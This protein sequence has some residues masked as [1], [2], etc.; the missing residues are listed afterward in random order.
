MSTKVNTE[1]IKPDLNILDDVKVPDKKILLLTNHDDFIQPYED[2]LTPG[3]KQRPWFTDFF[4]FCLPLSMGNQ[5]GFI[6][7]SRYD[8][9]L[10]WTGG[11]DLNAV[12][13][14][15]DYGENEQTEL[16]LQTFESHFGHGTVTMQMHYTMRT[17]PGVNILLKEPP[18]YPLPT[19][20]SVMNAVVETDQLR[21]DFTFNFKITEPHYDIFIPK[22]SPLAALVPYPRYFHDGYEVEVLKDKNQLETF[23]KSLEYFTQ[24]R[25]EEYQ[26]GSKPSLRYMKGE[27]VFGNKFDEHQKSLDGGKWWSNVKRKHNKEN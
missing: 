12:S 15:V 13:V 4:Y 2:I 26:K 20:L 6:V 1:K 24:E 25:N 9:L 17:P 11:N 16:K 23:R 14:F 3:C 7:Q 10:R 5:H 27:D 19:G 8:V 22:G 18:N 21:R